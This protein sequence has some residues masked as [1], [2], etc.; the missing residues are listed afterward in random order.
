[1]YLRKTPINQKISSQVTGFGMIFT[2]PFY[3]DLVRFPAK[4]QFSYA[5]K[6]LQGNE[7]CILRIFRE[8]GPA[9][10]TF[11]VP[12]HGFFLIYSF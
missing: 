11:F 4:N 2:C 1:M 3:L 5:L 12:Y 6:P 10:F 9:G 7:K 8:F